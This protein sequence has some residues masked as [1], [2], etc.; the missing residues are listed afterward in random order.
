MHQAVCICISTN[1]QV[2]CIFVRFTEICSSKYI[3]DVEKQATTPLALGYICV[4]YG[5]T[6]L[7]ILS[8]YSLGVQLT[9]KTSY[10]DITLKTIE[11]LK[12]RTCA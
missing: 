10:E 11:P 9:V 12:Q 5:T 1:I 7:C 8:C 3:E 4:P 6:L 2:V